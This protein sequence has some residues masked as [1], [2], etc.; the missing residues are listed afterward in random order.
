LEIKV[1][2]KNNLPWQHI[3]H[4]QI[5]LNFNSFLSTFSGRIQLLV[6]SW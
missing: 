1:I 6:V 4:F 3:F 2:P 5:E